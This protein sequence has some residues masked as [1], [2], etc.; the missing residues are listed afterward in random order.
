MK[1]STK[2]SAMKVCRKT[3]GLLAWCIIMFIHQDVVAQTCASK[4]LQFGILLPGQTGI[5]DKYSAQ[6]LC[7]TSGQLTTGTYRISVSLPANMSNGS[8]NIPLSFTSTDAA[9]WYFRAIWIGPTVYNPVNT[10]TTQNSTINLIVRL[11]ATIHV[12]SNAS[13]GYYTGPV[14]ITYQRI[15]T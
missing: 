1:P 13:P 10:I 9:Y 4:S 3:I 11:G 5:V 6:A 8:T 2:N 15:G 7:F 14:V 12:P